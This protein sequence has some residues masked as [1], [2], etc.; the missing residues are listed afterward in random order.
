MC[1]IDS[2]NLLILLEIIL[3]LGHKIISKYYS[4]E[5]RYEMRH[6]ACL[7]WLIRRIFV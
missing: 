7:E 4:L 2:V 1:P 3:F 6:G 5:A